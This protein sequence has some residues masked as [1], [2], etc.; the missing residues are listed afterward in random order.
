[1]N[2]LH[3]TERRNHGIWATFLSACKLQ[4]DWFIAFLSWK[5]TVNEFSNKVHE[6]SRVLI[7]IKG[8]LRLKQT[9]KDEQSGWEFHL[10]AK[11]SSK[12]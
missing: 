12:K 1:M 11:G 3:K 10:E 8:M 2:A 9:F 6:R 7:G 4:V 5:L